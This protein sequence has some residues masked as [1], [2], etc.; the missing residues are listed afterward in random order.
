MLRNLLMAKSWVEED[1]RHIK[2][3]FGARAFVA[4]DV[5]AAFEAI[6]N[7]LAREAD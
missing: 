4:Q 7:Y 2:E 1:L 5:K 6:N 3:H